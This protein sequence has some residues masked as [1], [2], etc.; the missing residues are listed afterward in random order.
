MSNKEEGPFNRDDTARI[1]M[2]KEITKPEI[3]AHGT[4][5]ELHKWSLCYEYDDYY[6][7]NYFS[8]DYLR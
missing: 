8:Y 7:F 5:T 4:L 1:F 6:Y 2:E 3:I